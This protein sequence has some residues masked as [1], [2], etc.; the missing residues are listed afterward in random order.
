MYELL[1]STPF[2]CGSK[3]KHYVRKGMRFGGHACGLWSM[4]VRST[5]QDPFQALS[6]TYTWLP[7]SYTSL[8]VFSIIWRES[9]NPGSDPK[10]RSQLGARQGSLWTYKEARSDVVR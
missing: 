1:P 8:N 3:L 4:H 6:R 9:W 10:R 5:D 7:T 2:S